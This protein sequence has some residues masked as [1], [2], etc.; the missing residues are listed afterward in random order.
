M[1]P[2]APLRPCRHPGCPNLVEV[3]G[4]CAA[5]IPKE[6]GRRPSAARRGYDANWRR[7]R[8]MILS[9]NPLCADPFGFH[10]ADGVIVLAE[11][12]DHIVPLAQ[13]GDNSIDNLQPLCKSCHSRKTAMTDG[14]F[15]GRGSKISTG[16]GH[17]TGAAVQKNQAQN[18][19]KGNAGA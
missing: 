15:G 1:M 5:H 10:K 7:L 16:F 19:S 4:Y 11:E 17:E 6:G 2:K 18:W 13:G 9:D 8:M 12:V 3:G 14:G